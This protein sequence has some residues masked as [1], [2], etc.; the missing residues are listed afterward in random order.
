MRYAGRPSGRPIEAAFPAQGYMPMRWTITKLTAI[1]VVAL[2]GVALA[3]SLFGRD[4]TPEPA[5]EP[6]PEVELAP[7]APPAAE[8][9]PM[10][11]EGL[12]VAIQETP[13]G[14]ANLSAQGCNACHWQAHDAWNQSPHA[15]AW[16]DPVFQEA[17]DRVGG[18]TSCRSCH[19]PLANQH[20]RLAAGYVDGD[21]ARPSLKPNELWD[22]TLMAEG[23][24]C[25]A[26]HVRDG[27]VVSTRAAP[28]APHPVAV[29][30][31]LGESSFC[32]TCHQLTWPGAEQPFYNT[33]GEWSASAYAEAGVGCKDCHMPAEA[34]PAIATR[35]AARPTHS[36]VADT[37]RAL[38]LLLELEESEIQRG[39][40]YTVTVRIQNTGAGHHVP[41]GS[42]FKQYRVEA[43]LLD[44]EGEPLAPTGSLDLGRTVSDGPPW[45][46]LADSRIPAGGEIRFAHSFTVSQRAAAQRAELVVRVVHASAGESP[47]VLTERRLALPVL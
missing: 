47:P 9:P 32:A 35:Y 27:T 38:S 33:F 6:A 3:G 18:S 29:S 34:G 4:K 23:V 2:G 10:F 30:A 7:P 26:C 36:F 12:P 14:L 11:P 40:E 25:A 31:E 41:T 15:V 46:I 45:D 24:S 42:P 28:G 20:P 1:A 16:S 44:A 5:P 39:S 8:A 22:P 19:L 13:P 17:V 21:L 43:L 37:G